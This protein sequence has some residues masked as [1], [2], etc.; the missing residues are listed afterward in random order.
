[1]SP[2]YTAGFN[3]RVLHNYDNGHAAAGSS[4]STEKGIDGLV[5]AL[6]GDE[7]IDGCPIFPNP[8]AR[9]VRPIIR[10]LP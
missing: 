5:D 1:M 9:A 7:V 8:R 3:T 10:L 2:D 6:P 4:H